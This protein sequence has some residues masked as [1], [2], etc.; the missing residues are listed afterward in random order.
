M[1]FLASPVIGPLSDR[2]GRPPVLLLSAAGMAADHGLM[3]LAPRLW[4][5]AVGPLLAGVTFASFTAVNA[6]VADTTPPEGRASPS[7]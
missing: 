6:C 7:V 1:Q 4:W 5:L 2:Y 3:A